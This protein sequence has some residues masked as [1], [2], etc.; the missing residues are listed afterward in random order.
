MQIIS[1]TNKEM[2]NATTP[3]IQLIELPYIE[4]SEKYAP[5][6]SKTPQNQVRL[7]VTKH[8][9]LELH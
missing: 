6:H 1:A 8:F 2:L 7:I 3:K 4:I 5:T 9:D